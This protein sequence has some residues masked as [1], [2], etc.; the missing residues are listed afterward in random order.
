MKKEITY[1]EAF[2]K[3]EELVEQLEGGDIQ[4]DKLTTKVNQ[5]NELINICEA[6]LRGIESD[7]NEATK[8]TNTKQKK[9]NE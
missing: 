1:S 6:K 7:V 4:L 5:A 9:I 8:P 2:I 3:L